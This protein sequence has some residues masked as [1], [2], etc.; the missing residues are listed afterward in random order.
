MRMGF[1]ALDVSVSVSVRRWS[2]SDSV[3]L[4]DS[5]QFSEIRGD[6]RAC[7]SVPVKS[8]FDFINASSCHSFFPRGPP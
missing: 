4:G 8:G 2:E 3:A 6:V 1:I 5:S 7:Y